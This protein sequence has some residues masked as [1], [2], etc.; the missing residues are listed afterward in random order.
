MTIPK[1]DVID[2]KGRGRNVGEGLPIP[3]PG[4]KTVPWKLHDCV[5]LTLL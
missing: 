5:L 4:Q 2:T 1:F 3:L